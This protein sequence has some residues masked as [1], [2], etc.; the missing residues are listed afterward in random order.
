M[1]YSSPFFP[2][3]LYSKKPAFLFLLLFVAALPLSQ[4][5]AQKGNKKEKVAGKEPTYPLIKQH[6]DKLYWAYFGQE[7]KIVGKDT[8][9]EVMTQRK[10]D[11]LVLKVNNFVSTSNFKNPTAKYPIVKHL[12]NYMLIASGKKL[13]PVKA[14][15]E[16]AKAE[17]EW[18]RLNDPTQLSSVTKNSTIEDYKAD[19]GLN[20]PADIIKMYDTCF[21]K[22]YH[23]IRGQSC[24]TGQPSKLDTANREP[25]KDVVLPP[26]AP[27]TVR[28]KTGDMLYIKFNDRDSAQVVDK[29]GKVYAGGKQL[30]EAVLKTINSHRFVTKYLAI[31]PFKFGMVEDGVIPKEDAHGN[32]Y[33]VLLRGSHVSD[34]LLFG[35]GKYTIEPKPGTRNA[36]LWGDYS[37]AI[38]E[39]IKLLI[40]PMSDF[41]PEVFEFILIGSADLDPDPWTAELQKGYNAAAFKHIRFTDFRDK[42]GGGY[43]YFPDTLHIGTS[44]G[45]KELPQLRAAYIREAL[46]AE[47]A[48]QDFKDRFR[49]VKGTEKKGGTRMD[50]NCLILLYINRD[51]INKKMDE[52]AAAHYSPF[53]KP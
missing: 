24:T 32:F 33:Q 3:A 9:I 36:H 13:E 47:P 12:F 38:E 8:A 43:E 34:T 6:Y 28:S 29:N 21:A 53:A 45:N 41:G 16:L 20:I 5:Q 26:P 49:I 46:L 11:E 39:F 17:E 31:T 25:P 27:D 4:L 52:K 48:F 35:T 30:A 51:V 40:D 1:H 37:Q 7:Q 23:I 10:R 14:C 19:F 18:K 50:R 42:P 15:E 2:P 22:E 44:Y